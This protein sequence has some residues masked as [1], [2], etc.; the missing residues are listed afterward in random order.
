MKI[1]EENFEIHKTTIRHT[2]KKINNIANKNLVV[3]KLLFIDVTTN[4]HLLQN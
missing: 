1:I 2:F 4:E 3:V